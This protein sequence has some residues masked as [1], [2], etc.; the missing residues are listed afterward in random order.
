MLIWMGIRWWPVGDREFRIAKQE[1]TIQGRHNVY[2]TMAAILAAL[3]TGVS[4]EDLRTG[5]DNIPAGGTSFGD[6]GRG[7]WSYLY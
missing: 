7:E 2:N 6:G 1:V 5:I 3:K 4:D